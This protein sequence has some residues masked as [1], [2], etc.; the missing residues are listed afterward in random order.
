MTL[1]SKVGGKASFSNSTVATGYA[2]ISSVMQD[3]YVPIAIG[4][5][6][7]NA[8]HAVFPYGMDFSADTKQAWINLRRY[9]NTK[10]TGDVGFNLV[11]L[12]KKNT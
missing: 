12:F 2:D 7:L 1:T 6:Y 5:F 10:Y 11:V 9:D 3:G 8:G 4:G